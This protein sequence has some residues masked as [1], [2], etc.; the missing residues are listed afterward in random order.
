MSKTTSNINPKYEFIA[1]LF[2]LLLG[3]IT[4]AASQ[5][6]QIG[7]LSQMGPGYFPTLLGFGLVLVGLFMLLDF[8]KN[9]GNLVK[10]NQ[11]KNS[12]RGLVFT[13]AGII[14]F[15]FAVDVLGFLIAAFVLILLAA[16]GDRKNSLKSSFLL[17]TVLTAATTAIFYFGLNIQFPLSPW[18]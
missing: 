12:Y 17:A 5:Q 10:T 7:T 14:F 8:N 15:I 1:S 18:A 3:L 11:T 4:I 13:I 2:I 16:L 9:K 6:Y